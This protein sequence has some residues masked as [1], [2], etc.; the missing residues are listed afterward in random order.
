MK[1]L[2]SGVL[3][4]FI[5]IFLCCCRSKNKIFILDTIYAGWYDYSIEYDIE[6]FEKVY[7]NEIEKV[8][9]KIIIKHS[10]YI[11]FN[12]KVTKDLSG[13]IEMTT[14]SDFESFITFKEKYFYTYYSYIHLMNGKLYIESQQKITN[15]R[16]VWFHFTYIKKK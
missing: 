11:I 1:K 9:I 3:L 16:P 10:S 4:S 12:G 15:D 8:G 2:I 14:F 7:P 6:S 5:L 13:E